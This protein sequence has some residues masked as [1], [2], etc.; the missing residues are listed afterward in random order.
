[1]ASG[2]VYESFLVSAALRYRY[3]PGRKRGV[4]D[5]PSCNFLVRNSVMQALGGFDTK[6]WP[7]EDTKLCLD[8]TK[9]LGLKIIYDP[10]VLVY[11]HRR[12][13]FEPHLKQIASYALH[14]GYF[15][16][17]YPKTSFKL[18]YFIPTLFLLA[19][20]GG[21]ALSLS[22]AFFRTIF[23]L[24]LSLYLILAFLFS[25]SGSGRLVVLVFFGTILTHL[26]YGTYFLKGL[27]SKKLPEEVVKKNE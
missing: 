6:L 2:R 9:R 8:I 20:V 16:R 3:L 15:V 23:S 22:S 7:G 14:R 18:A 10:S 26:T 27:L 25:I 12:P 1:M 17:K 11:H 13:L 24:C 4:D 21:S 5:F 19:L